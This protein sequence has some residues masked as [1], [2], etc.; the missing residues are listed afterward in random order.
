M[1]LP[2]AEG[3]VT[4]LL[5]GLE[6]LSRRLGHLP[7]G[8]RGIEWQHGGR[9][10][11]LRLRRFC[12]LVTWERAL[13]SSSPPGHFLQSESRWDF[14]LPLEGWGRAPRCRGLSGL[15]ALRHPV[16][17][18]PTPEAGVLGCRAGPPPT[19]TLPF[20]L[21]LLLPSLLAEPPA[22][23]GCAPHVALPLHAEPD[24]VAPVPDA[25]PGGGPRGSRALRLPCPG[26]CGPGPLRAGAPLTATLLS[27]GRATPRLLAGPGAACVSLGR[28][29]GCS[30][31][32]L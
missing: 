30:L 24:V 16:A 9:H 4:Q 23:E 19:K 6:H 13:G 10:L 25:R 5:Q 12:V 22:T 15:G 7:R 18:L 27:L 21:P 17:E 1:L 32:P 28:L 31:W 14:L 8:P 29:R 2:R 26:C 20:L 11:R 3:S